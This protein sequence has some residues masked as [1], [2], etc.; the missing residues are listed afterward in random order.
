MSNIVLPTLRQ[1]GFLVAVADELHF[2]RAAETCHITQ[3]ALSNGL[4]ELEEILQVRLVERTKRSVLMTPIGG[5][6]AERARALL[7]DAREI[8]EIASRQSAPM[9]GTLRLG[10]IP[11]IGPYL[12]PHALPEIRRLFP[13]LKFYLR[14]DKTN[15]LLEW[16]ADGRLDLLLI[17]LPFE[18]G[19]YA[20]EPLFEDGYDLATPPDH[21]LA[22]KAA[23]GGKELAGQP[24][25]LLEVGHCLQRHALSAY[26]NS[27]T[28]Q[29]ESFEATSLPTLVAMVEEGLGITLL[30]KLAVDAGVASGRD[31]ALTPLKGA[32][33]RRVC[34]VW[35]PT[36][37]KANDFKRL[38]EVIRQTHAKISGHGP[39]RTAAE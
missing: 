25:L 12:L 28:L 21:I 5:E 19:G 22:A 29:D 15:E 23:L 37:A 31:I 3:S 38:A 4:K 17:A 10:A 36:S 1:L 6:I 8:S 33:P 7:A 9:S 2:G 24:L 34:L 35:R 13:D 32:C 39:Q 26:P 27:G 18:I 11:T 16:L 20:V 30:P 14:E